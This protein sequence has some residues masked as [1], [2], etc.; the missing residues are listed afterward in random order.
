M[1][2]GTRSSGG[3]GTAAGGHV[4]AP[5][6]NDGVL[7]GWGHCG[8][9][10]RLVIP[11]EVGSAA[12]S[13]CPA[14]WGH[15]WVRLPSCAVRWRH[16][17]GRRAYLHHHVWRGRPVPPTLACITLLLSRCGQGCWLPPDLDDPAGT[18]Q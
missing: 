5:P 4:K 12:L 6:R 11:C 10:I 14:S 16:Q 9:L 18:C 2:G 1:G 15:G 17:V 8:E 13:A 7:F 3:G